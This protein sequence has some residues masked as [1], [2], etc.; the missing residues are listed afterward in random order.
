LSQI[1]RILNTLKEKFIFADDIEI[2]IEVNPENI[3]K[4]NL[5]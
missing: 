2:T 4:E 5:I 1:E 3:T